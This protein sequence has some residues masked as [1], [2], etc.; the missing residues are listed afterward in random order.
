[1]IVA[2]G[3]IS[4][5]IPRLDEV[6]RVMRDTQQRVR[7]QRGCVSYAFAEALDD[8]GHFFVMQEWQDLAAL[9]GHYRSQAFADYQDAIAP[10]LVRDTD[11]RVSET[12]QSVRPVADGGEDLR[13]SD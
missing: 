1:M 13:P 5:K 12:A 10:L 2:L 6:R 9:D 3:D 8:P 7:E 11:L 4:A